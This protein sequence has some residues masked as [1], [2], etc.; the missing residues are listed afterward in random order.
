MLQGLG[1]LV[2]GRLRLWRSDDQ[3]LHLA[4]GIDAPWSLPLPRGPGLVSTP[5]GPAW[6]EPVDGATGVWLE[7]AGERADEL[8]QAAIG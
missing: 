4:G 8:G 7:I 6:M 3:S 2:G 5:G 1:S